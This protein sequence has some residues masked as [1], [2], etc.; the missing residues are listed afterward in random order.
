M[1]ESLKK[2]CKVGLRQLAGYTP[3]L[4]KTKVVFDKF[5]ASIAINRENETFGC[6]TTAER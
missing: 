3:T 6:K 1:L 2:P 4:D 5:S